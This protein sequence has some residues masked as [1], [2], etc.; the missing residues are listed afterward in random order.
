MLLS[1]LF[2]FVRQACATVLHFWLPRTLSRVPYGLGEKDALVGAQSELLGG[3]VFVTVVEPG[4][5]A[6]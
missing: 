3:V 5:Q 6:L 2:Y 4:G 1:F